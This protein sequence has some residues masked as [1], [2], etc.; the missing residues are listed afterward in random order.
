MY[1]EIL[2]RLSKISFGLV[3]I[4]RISYHC[5]RFVKPMSG[6]LWDTGCDDVEGWKAWWGSCWGNSNDA[7]SCEPKVLG[8][9]IYV[10]DWN[11]NWKRN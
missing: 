7:R 9:A 8:S 11:K 2:F 4:S 3:L 1:C 6:V 10:S 5:H